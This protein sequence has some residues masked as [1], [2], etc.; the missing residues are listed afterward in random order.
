LRRAEWRAPSG[1]RAGLDVLGRRQGGHQVEGLENE[2]DRFRAQPGERFLAQRAQVGAVQLDAAVGGPVEG[3]EQVQQRGLAAPGAPLHGQPAAVFD[4]QVQVPDS[5]D[6]A[7]AFVAEL[8]NP[9]QSSATSATGAV[10]DRSDS[11]QPT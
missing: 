11:D 4:D 10:S 8:G 5:R 6:D 3:A 2:P 9:G 1:I 7:A